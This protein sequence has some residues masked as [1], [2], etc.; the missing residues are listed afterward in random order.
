MDANS[1][2]SK[3]IFLL[4][5]SQRARLNGKLTLNIHLTQKQVKANIQR[6][7]MLAD[8]AAKALPFLLTT[9]L[10]PGVVEN[11]FGI[12]YLYLHPSRRRNGGDGQYL[13][14]SVHCVQ[15]EPTKGKGL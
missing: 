11:A 5:H 2:S 1:L 7:G 10:M 6:H 8:L 14:K 12:R 9:G 15:V 13:H 3:H 4:A